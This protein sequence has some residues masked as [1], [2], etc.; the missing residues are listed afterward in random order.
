[1]KD[2][3]LFEVILEFDPA[4]VK[5]LEL[6]SSTIKDCNDAL[7]DSL[8][9][10]REEL[11]GHP[12]QEICQTNKIEDF[13]LLNSRI[14]IHLNRINTEEKKAILEFESILQNLYRLTGV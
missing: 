5:R 7:A 14:P 2:Y 11:I 6:Q 9:Y 10:T 8:G 1:M 12:L 3:S 13:S 4:G